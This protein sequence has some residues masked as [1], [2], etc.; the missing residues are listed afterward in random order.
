MVSTQEIINEIKDNFFIKVKKGK[1]LI[2]G[3]VLDKKNASN[4]NFVSINCQSF[5]SLQP[6][7]YE[8]S[9]NNISVYC[10][11]CFFLGKIGFIIKAKV[12]NCSL[13]DF[14]VPIPN[15][16]I[17]KNLNKKFQNTYKCMKKK[18][19]NSKNYII[20]FFQLMEV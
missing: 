18:Y 4:N 17:Y 20:K 1:T 6:Y 14:Y 16:M 15:N 7:I 9:N 8:N 3:Y 13:N 11:E 5:V 12:K 2:Y 10:C 19:G